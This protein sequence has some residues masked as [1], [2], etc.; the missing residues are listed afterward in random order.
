MQAVI[1]DCLAVGPDI[2]KFFH[3]FLVL[4]PDS[5][6]GRLSGTG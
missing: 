3:G 2:L 6:I 1:M 5:I 4:P